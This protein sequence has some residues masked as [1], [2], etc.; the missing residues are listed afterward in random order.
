MRTDFRRFHQLFHSVVRYPRPSNPPA[1]RGELPRS[2]WLAGAAA[3]AA[4]ATTN[5]NA[6]QKHLVLGLVPVP[7]AVVYRVLRYVVVVVVHQT[8]KV[9]TACVRSSALV[10]NPV[11]NPNC[12]TPEVAVRSIVRWF[13]RSKSLSPG[14]LGV[15][16]A[17]GRS[18]LVGVVRVLW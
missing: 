17:L 15:A 14:T 3:A 12:V 8:T 6:S 2:G 11:G 5:V 18:L 10:E 16:L 9:L 1:L 13:V 4:A 7:A